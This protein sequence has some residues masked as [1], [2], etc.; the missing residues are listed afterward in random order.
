MPSGP[1]TVGCSIAGGEMAKSTIMICSPYS[2]FTSIPV[3]CTAVSHCLQIMP[4]NAVHNLHTSECPF[5]P[6]PYRARRHA[7]LWVMKCAKLIHGI[8]FLTPARQYQQ[9][10]EICEPQ[11]V[12]GHTKPMGFSGC[13]QTT[14]ERHES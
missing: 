3:D 8:N 7:H 12:R 9:T 4:D 10:P 13:A 11:I 5:Q 1:H 2:R 14:A 6:R